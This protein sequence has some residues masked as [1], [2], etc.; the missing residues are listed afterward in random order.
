MARASAILSGALIFLILSFIETKFKSSVYKKFIS[1]NEEEGNK[2]LPDI[3]GGNFM[4]KIITIVITIVM[5]VGL[6]VPV[7][8]TKA[9]A[10][11]RVVARTVSDMVANLR[12]GANWD[13]K[14][15][16][17]LTPD[18]DWI[19]VN[20]LYHGGKYHITISVWY[21]LPDEFPVLHESQFDD[22]TIVCTGDLG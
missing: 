10:A 4:K 15:F 22:D 18:D 3:L 11:E 5:M 21:T 20:G 1:Y 13:E 9:E 2:A 6:V 7:N 8:T 12:D 19:Y 16:V 17:Y 14:A